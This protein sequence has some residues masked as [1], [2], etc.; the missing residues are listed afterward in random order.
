MRIQR[1]QSVCSDTKI[2]HTYTCKFTH[3]RTYTYIH[4]Y[5]VKLIRDYEDT[6]AG[7]SLF[8]HEEETFEPKINTSVPDFKTLQADFQVLYACMRVCMYAYVCVLGT[9]KKLLIQK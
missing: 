6:K 2:K 9:K 4:T 1:R 3:T 8:R 7:I 5:Q